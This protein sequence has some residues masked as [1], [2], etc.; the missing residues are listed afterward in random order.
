VCERCVW[1]LVKKAPISLTCI[2]RP[3]L[4]LQTGSPFLLVK[5]DGLDVCSAK[6]IWF[7]FDQIIFYHR[8]SFSPAMGM[9][10]KAFLAYA[11]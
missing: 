4:V 1:T 10:F 6:K 2:R 9:G 3:F 11:K 8:F 7:Q 5:N